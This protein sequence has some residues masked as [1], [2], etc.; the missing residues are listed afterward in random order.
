M[1]K[2]SLLINKNQIANPR[3]QNLYLLTGWIM[4]AA[5]IAVITIP[6][7]TD[8]GIPV[9][10]SSWLLLFCLGFSLIR[11]LY[12]GRGFTD[13]VMGIFASIFYFFAQWAAG[14]PFIEVI[15]SFRM[16][17]CITIFFAGLSKILTY[18][19]LHSNIIL[20]SLLI[21][22]FIDLCVSV[23]LIFGFPGFD[24]FYVYWY[25]GLAVISDGIV[26]FYNSKKIKT[27]RNIS[28]FK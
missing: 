1:L 25:I 27:M 2:Q 21:D 9:F 13:L 4:L 18:A 20:T 16:I 24:A 19:S 23:F 28:I 7:F 3:E 12:F 11:P 8:K 5:G 26:Y 6:I 17:I 15:L 14:S 22:G 10:I